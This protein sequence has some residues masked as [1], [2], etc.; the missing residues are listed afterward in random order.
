MLKEDPAAE[1]LDQPKG[2]EDS[3]DNAEPTNNKKK[4]YYTYN[5]SATEIDHDNLHITE[6]DGMG[7]RMKHKKNNR[8]TSAS[9]NN[10]NKK[11]P[12]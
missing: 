12:G 9:N 10:S 8:N 5:G 6:T 4:Q 11:A 1:W 3:R 7:N 2:S